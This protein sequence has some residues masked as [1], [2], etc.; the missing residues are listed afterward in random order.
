[1]QDPEL[2]EATASEPLT[3][4]QEIEMQHE[5]RDDEKKCTF[6][7]LARDLI[8]G[9]GCDG[10]GEDSVDVVPPSPT[11]TNTLGET[12][13]VDD[14]EENTNDNHH[15][16]EREYPLLVDQTLHDDWRC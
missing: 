9:A 2:L 5:W 7:I 8:N 4:E 11:A 16:Q 1:M 6:I 10:G 13:E 3:M 14:E 15:V 12:T